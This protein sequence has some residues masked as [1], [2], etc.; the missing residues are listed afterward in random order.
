MYQYNSKLITKNDIFICLP[1]GEAYI[2]DALA[3]GATKVLK[4][5]REE[6]AEL[7]AS[8]FGHPS[9]K[10]TVIGITGTNGKTTVTNLIGQALLKAGFTPFVLGTINANLTTPESLDI[11]RIMAEHLANNGTHFIMEV[12]SHGIAQK[13][14]HCIDFD[15]K[16]LTNITQDH[17]DFH[18]TFENYK[19]TKLS[20][21]N[22]SECIKIFPQD[23]K[24]IK[25]DFPNPLLGNFNHE[26]MQAS[27]LSLQKLHISASIISKALSRA[28]SPPGRFENISCGQN[29]LVI[30]DYAH[31]PDGLEKILKTAKDL[32]KNKQN[33]LITVFGCGGD[34]D[35]GK[36]SKMGKI[37]SQLS[38]FFIITKD[39]PRT[40]S[41][42]QITSDILQGIPDSIQNYEIIEDRKKAIKFAIKKAQ[43]NDVVI[44]AGKGH[45][46]YQILN[47]GT[48]HFDDREEVRCAIKER[49][50]A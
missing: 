44:I 39:N 12:S 4:M 26:N 34:R 21:M 36:R 28:T 7:A 50:S 16:L 35:R 41:Q 20:F 45:E 10:L 24:N 25:L 46:N 5:G 15:L 27:V 33:K 38:D 47:S 6:M 48:I 31:T 2:D 49:L 9:E 8:H 14:I 22:D 3:R 18:K 43:T 37:T 19:K 42:A 29:F 30:V 40:E 17:L 1:G 32:A 23:Y 13:R 11:Q